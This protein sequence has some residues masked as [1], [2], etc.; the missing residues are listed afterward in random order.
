MSTSSNSSGSRDRRDRRGSRRRRSGNRTDS[1][2]PGAPSYSKPSQRPAKKKTLWEKILGFF[3]G[4]DSKSAI[5]AKAYGTIPDQPERFPSAQPERKRERKE[6]FSNPPR[7]RTRSGIRKPEEVEVTSPRLYVGNLSFDAT[8]SDLSEL[9]AGAGTVQ[10]VEVVGD[11]RT[12]R[13]KG[14]GFVQMQTIEEARRAVSELHDKEFMGRKLVVSGAKALDERR[15][16]ERR[17]AR[18]NA[19]AESAES[20]ETVESNEGA[21]LQPGQ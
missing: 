14:F 17:A 10:A 19:Q 9:F 18:E 7:E 15:S 5:P 21:Q 8:E 6:P 1:R 16:D 13:S 12:M 2:S 20:A 4:D 11:K 3:K